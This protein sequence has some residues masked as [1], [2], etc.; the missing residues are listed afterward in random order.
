MPSIS[1]ILGVSTYLAHNEKIMHHQK[2]GASA[3]MVSRL[4]LTCD[5][6]PAATLMAELRHTLALATHE[7]ADGTVCFTVVTDMLA[8]NCTS[9]VSTLPMLAYEVL[10]PHVNTHRSLC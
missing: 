4:V 1:Y 3:S 6:P 8:I 5:A 2:C 9:G 10:K 7:L